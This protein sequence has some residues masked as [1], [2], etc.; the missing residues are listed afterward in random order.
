MKIKDL[1]QIISTLSDE[2]KEGTLLIRQDASESFSMDSVSQIELSSYC[3]GAT[4]EFCLI[5]N[6]PTSEFHKESSSTTKNFK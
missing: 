1:E 5:F 6:K 4:N 2:E 3:T